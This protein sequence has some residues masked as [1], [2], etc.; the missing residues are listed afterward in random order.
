MNSIY[1]YVYADSRLSPS[2]RTLSEDWSRFCYTWNARIPWYIRV[3]TVA[4]VKSQH[5]PA[6]VQRA[7]DGHRHTHKY[8]SNS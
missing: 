2:V 6:V 4:I 5:T 8:I 3:A 1:I 7:I